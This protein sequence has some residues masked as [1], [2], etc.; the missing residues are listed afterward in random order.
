MCVCVCVCV[1]IH[2]WACVCFHCN[3]H[4]PSESKA[5][6]K[7]RDCSLIC[8]LRPSFWVTGKWMFIILS[9]LPLRV[10]KFFQNNK[11]EK[12][13]RL[14]LDV[15]SSG[16]ASLL[17]YFHWDWRLILSA[18]R[19][20]CEWLSPYTLILKLWSMDQQQGYN[21]LLFGNAD[22]RAEFWLP[23]S[24]LHFDK[25]SRWSSCTVKFVKLS[26]FLCWIKIAFVSQ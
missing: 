25:I 21:W 18:S 20:F 26:H 13:K 4:N 11:L 22:S 5:D 12:K 17:S 16:K 15:A 7:T 8:L 23:N 24:N 10:I 1:Y 14:S 2:A 6:Y 3:T 19:E 9:S